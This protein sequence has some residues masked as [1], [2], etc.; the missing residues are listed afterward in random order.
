MPTN[1]GNC[2][3]CR[4]CLI[5]KQHTDRDHPHVCDVCMKAV[6]AREPINPTPNGPRNTVPLE[7][8]R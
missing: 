7:N 1:P 6:L 8:R 5:D 4:R 3:Y 2:V